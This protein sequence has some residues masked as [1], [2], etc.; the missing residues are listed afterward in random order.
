MGY[1]SNF[2]ADK[3]EI[4]LYSEVCPLLI[5]CYAG[6]SVEAK[7]CDLMVG[8]RE[9]R[10]MNLSD[11]LVRYSE[12]VKSETSTAYLGSMILKGKYA[13]LVLLSCYTLLTSGE[14]LW[15]QFAEKDPHQLTRADNLPVEDFE[16]ATDAYLEGYIQA[17]VDMHYYEFK[18]MVSVRD[19]RV[20]L[21]HLPTNE[22]IAHSIIAFVQDVPGVKS[23]EVR[24]EF[25]EHEL[26]IRA[27]YT[28]QP[29]VDGVWFPQM[30]VLFQP[31]I[32][33]PREP[34]YYVAYRMGDRVVGRKSIAVALG[35][36]FPIFR[37]RNVLRWH[38]DMQIGIQAG[39]WAIFNFSHV[40]NDEMCELVNTDYFLGIPL[41]Y[42][43]GRWSFRMR[44]YH[45]S[46]HLGDEFLVDH[47]EYLLQRKNPSY[48]ALDFVSSYQLS[49]AVRLYLGPGVIL[50]SDES[51]KLKRLYFVYGT[52]IR[53]GGRKLY[54]HRLYGTPFLALFIA[55]RQQQHWEFDTT[56]KV[57]Y[58]ISKLQGI[59][60]KMR[61]F[62]EYHNGF[63]CEG[64]FFNLRTQYG[65]FG[66]SWGF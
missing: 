24:Q 56:L 66:F 19:H 11:C 49:Q 31:L 61:L 55:N 42:A 59:G 34:M 13:S 50:H 64:Q 23:V 58:E 30:T 32:A 2:F 1:C 9:L 14:H 46:G 33:D 63:S 37:W 45:I 65:Q 25:S 12:S 6:F 47:P 60:R 22:L 44:L 52:E 20:L 36:D 38:G 57:G 4:V 35:D 53:V 7:G 43:A 17:L 51:F 54:Y 26:A 28:E 41:T 27:T 29:R 3:R 16:H 62:A 8:K 40:P 39:V 15:G 5:G 10:R 21:G 18:V 48:E